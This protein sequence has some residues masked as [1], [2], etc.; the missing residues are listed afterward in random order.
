MINVLAW[1][2]IVLSILMAGAIYFGYLGAGTDRDK[3]ILV[4]GV[5][6]PSFSIVFSLFVLF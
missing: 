6:P 4:A 3:K 1:V 5:V 2:N